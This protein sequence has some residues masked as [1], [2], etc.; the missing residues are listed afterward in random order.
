MINEVETTGETESV[1]SSIVPLAKETQIEVDSDC[2]TAS[3]VSEMVGEKVL[4]ES[5]D[6]DDNIQPPSSP[7]N[8]SSSSSSS[9]SMTSVSITKSIEKKKRKTISPSDELCPNTSETEGPAP[10]KQLLE[11]LRR[12][13]EN[14]FEETQIESITEIKTKDTENIEVVEKME[15]QIKAVTDIDENVLEANAAAEIAPSSPIVDK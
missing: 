13:S 9:S 10:K 8:P 14:I 1:T 6:N 5:N 4:G 12:N 11:S 15:I 2:N 7:P 3:E